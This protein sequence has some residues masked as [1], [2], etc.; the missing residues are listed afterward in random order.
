MHALAAQRS[1]ELKNSI[2]CGV[3]LSVYAEREYPYLPRRLIESFLAYYLLLTQL[4]THMFLTR[5]VSLSL[6]APRFYLKGSLPCPIFPSTAINTG[7]LL[8]NRHMATASR[9]PP[10]QQ[11]TAPDADL[12]RLAVYNS[13]TRSKVPFVPIDWK[14]KTVSWYNCGPTTWV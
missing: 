14:T 7:R 4:T 5:C 2:I 3:R 1:L 9:Q 10:W 11:P 8:L 13:L 12:P 6:K